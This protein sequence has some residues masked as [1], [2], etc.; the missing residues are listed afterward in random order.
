MNVQWLILVKLRYLHSKLV[1][2]L[3]HVQLARLSSIAVKFP[4]KIKKFSFFKLKVTF[5]KLPG[6]MANLYKIYN[7]MQ[8]IDDAVRR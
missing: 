4:K 2:Y 5:K 6:V 1:Y 7:G 8:M 3:T